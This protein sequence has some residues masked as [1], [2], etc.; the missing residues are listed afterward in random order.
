[1]PTVRDYEDEKEL[2]QIARDRKKEKRQN[3]E[4]KDYREILN[5]KKEKRMNNLN[6]RQMQM[7]A[8]RK[9]AVGDT[10]TGSRQKVNMPVP[11][12]DDFGRN[13]TMTKGRTP[14]GNAYG[15]SKTPRGNAYGRNYVMANAKKPGGRY[16]NE[17]TQRKLVAAGATGFNPGN[18]Y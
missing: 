18:R 2:V 10:D 5:N 8:M 9:R 14:R 6:R 11:G 1:M 7:E 13:Y 15:R 12:G 17:P 4:K 16:Y 3:I